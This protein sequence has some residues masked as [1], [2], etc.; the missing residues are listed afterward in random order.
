[1]AVDTAETDDDVLGV[2]GQQFEEVAVV[3]DLDQQFLHVVRLVGVIRDQGVQRMI[4][5]VG[6]IVGRR[7]RRLLAVVGRDEVHEAAQHGQR[8]DVVLEGQIGHTGLAGVGDGTAQFFGGHVLVGH[9]LHDFRT[10]HE[11]VG[12]VLDHEDEIGHRRAIHGTAGTGAH[13][14]R[15]LRHD[16][17]GHDVALENVGVA[18]QG[19]NAF[20]DTRTAR[21]VQADHRG[22]DLHRLVHDLADFLGVGFRQR[23]A[24]HS[25]ILREDEDQT[26]ID[27]AIAD[28]NAVAR[29]LFGLIHAEVDATVLLEHVPFF[30]GT[31]IEQQLDAFAG[32]QLALLVLAVDTL[33]ATAEAGQFTLLLKLAD[34][35]MHGKTPSME[36]VI[37]VSDS[38]AAHTRRRPGSYVLLR[39]N[40]SARAGFPERADEGGNAGASRRR[41]VA[42][43]RPATGAGAWRRTRR[44][45]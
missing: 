16:A 4:H 26:T 38:R 45:A 32:R 37:S 21:I 35:V 12:R 6:R 7:D 41:S 25:E 13:D 5:A 1:M 29:S 11:H 9:G 10:G 36:R 30:E 28:H 24:E 27:G 20:L 18:A 22:A 23:A 33:L 42:T 43:S 34:D 3:D 44:S 2:V 40:G 15:N 17:G 8:F 14:H 31:R 19:S 39:R